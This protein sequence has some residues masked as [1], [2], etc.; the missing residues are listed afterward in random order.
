MNGF[1]I[2]LDLFLGV[3]L[4]AAPHY[5]PAG[6]A[7]QTAVHLA[8]SVFGRPDARAWHLLIVATGFLFVDPADLQEKMERAKA[9]LQPAVS[10]DSGVSSSARRNRGGG[11]VRRPLGGGGYSAGSSGGR[12]GGRERPA[13][14]TT[15]AVGGS[16]ASENV[17][18]SAAAVPTGAGESTSE[19]GGDSGG[20]RP[21]KKLPLQPRPSS[22]VAAL[23]TV[24]V[25][26]QVLLPLRHVLGSF[27]VEWSREGHE[28]SW[29]AGG[30]VGGRGGGGGLVREE[31]L[32]RVMHQ[33]RGR[34]STRR[35]SAAA[36]Q[37]VHLYGSPF[38]AQQVCSSSWGWGRADRCRLR[39]RFMV[40]PA[41]RVRNHLHFGGFSERFSHG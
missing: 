30:G 23:I 25:L 12:V 17:R 36:V 1:M 9:W 18:E 29:R 4:L 7:I 13:G 41:T 8:A 28:F 19:G 34:G 5:R 31:A 39:P 11:R 16:G 22:P 40:P 21:K 33:P 32:V 6:L 27:P 2:F 14:G 35:G 15:R 20:V 37:T 3:S 24:Y 38:T 10:Y 26:A